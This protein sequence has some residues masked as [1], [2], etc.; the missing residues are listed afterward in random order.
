VDFQHQGEERLFFQTRRVPSPVN[1]GI[2]VFLSLT[3]AAD[4]TPSTA[5]E[6][7]SLQLTCTHRSLPRELRVGDV[8][9]VTSGSP[10]ISRFENILPV[11]P[12]V[13]PP[14]GMELHWRLLS[15]LALNRRSLAHPESL[16]ALLNLYNFQLNADT[17]DAR[18][19]AMKVSAIRA[20]EPMPARHVVQ[21]AVISGQ[22][23]TVE[24]EEAS[25]AGIGDVFLLGCVLD[26]LFAGYATLNSFH[27]LSVR[28][29]PSRE[30]LQWPVRS[31]SQAL[32]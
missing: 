10:T 12:P 15:H 4:V 31:G 13:R 2:D 20:V 11:T 19:I 24:I 22:K 7:L 5:E 21:G 1:D 32:V 17:P 25:F 9:K 8:R 28:L 16:S 18:A 27:S 6:T 26:A 29:L 23:T 3:G 30:E 14:L